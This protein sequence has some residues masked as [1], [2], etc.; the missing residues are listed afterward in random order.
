MIE[1]TKSA[2]HFGTDPDPGIGTTDLRIR[3]QILLFS[4][5]ADKMQVKNKYFLKVF[6]FFNFLQENLRLSSKIKRQKEVH[7]YSIALSKI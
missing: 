4:S 6:M 1:T 5:L 3:I 7:R 2:R